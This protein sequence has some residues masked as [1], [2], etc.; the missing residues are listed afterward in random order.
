VKRVI[1]VDR[2][3]QRDGSGADVTRLVGAPSKAPSRRAPLTKH[4]S[5]FEA[6]ETVHLLYEPHL[7]WMNEESRADEGYY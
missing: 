5:R 1:R 2:L 3:I 4:V 7:L 6:H